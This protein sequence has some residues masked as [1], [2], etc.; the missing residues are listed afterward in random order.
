MPALQAGTAHRLT[1]VRAHC[2]ALGLWA[3]RVALHP[4]YGKHVVLVHHAELFVELAHLLRH[5]DHRTSTSL[6]CVRVLQPPR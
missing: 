5:C 3:D 2:L 6:A 4:H 1:V